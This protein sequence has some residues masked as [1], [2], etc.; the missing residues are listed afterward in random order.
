M[1]EEDFSPSVAKGGKETLATSFVSAPLSEEEGK[2]RTREE[3]GEG[4]N[5]KSKRKKKARQQDDVA[6]PVSDS[7]R[8]M[9]RRGGG[10]L[11]SSSS[12]P[13]PQQPNH[14]N[15]II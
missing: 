13:R 10:I 8:V 3:R 6:D 5:A 7:G 14:Q 4:E 15:M 1:L 2:T 12:H 9:T 11:F